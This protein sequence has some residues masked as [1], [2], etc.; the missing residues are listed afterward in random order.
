MSTDLLHTHSTL[1]GV[2]CCVYMLFLSNRLVT[3]CLA[4]TE[5]LHRHLA[6]ASM[7]PSYYL[8]LVSYVIY[9]AVAMLKAW[10]QKHGQQEW[11]KVICCHV[12]FKAIYADLPPTCDRSNSC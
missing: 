5:L 8:C 2:S 11:S 9:L 4:I 7:Q 6:P 10:K 3:V 1:A 12:N